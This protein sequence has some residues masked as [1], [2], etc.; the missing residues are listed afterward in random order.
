MCLTITGKV[1]ELNGKNAIV[2]IE[3]KRNRVKANPKVPMEVGDEVLIFRNFIID[4]VRE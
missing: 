4:K 1:I 2:E 3:D